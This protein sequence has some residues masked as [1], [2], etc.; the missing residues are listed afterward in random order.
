MASI[1]AEDL[2]LLQHDG[3]TEFGGFRTRCIYAVIEKMLAL[4]P[5][6]EHPL[7]LA[8]LDRL[9]LPNYLLSRG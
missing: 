6:M 9:F 2:P 8:L 7:I 1:K 3:R 5:L 4:N